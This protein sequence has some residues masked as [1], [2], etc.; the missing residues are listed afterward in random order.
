MKKESLK[1]CINDLPYSIDLEKNMNDIEAVAKECD[2]FYGNGGMPLTACVR[3][4][5]PIMIMN[6]NL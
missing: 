6:I 5:I 1:F 2:A 3:R 4:Q